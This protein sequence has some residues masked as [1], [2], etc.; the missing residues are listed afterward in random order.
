VLKSCPIK[1][2]KVGTVLA[3]CVSKLI[4]Q[5]GYKM[6]DVQQMEERTMLL[7][8]NAGNVKSKAMEAVAAAKK[9]DFDKAEGLLE[10]C[11]LAMIEAHKI[12]NEFIQDSLDDTNLPVSLLMTHAEDHMM[13]AIL[14]REF[15]EEIIELH[16]LLAQLKK[17]I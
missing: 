16:R 3:Y 2:Y 7:V 12:Q 15:G 13:G 11:N 14:A 1:K 6:V 8:A 4:L 17:E 10:E 5:R 9:G